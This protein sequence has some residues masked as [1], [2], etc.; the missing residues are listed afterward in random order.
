VF[1]LV[2][3]E[4]EHGHVRQR[5]IAYLG[6]ISEKR[7]QDVAARQAVWR[8]AERALAETESLSDAQ[9]ERMRVQLA[10]YVAMPARART[11][12]CL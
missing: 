9:R 4:R 2:K 11:E 8:S 6:T 5:G 7:V 3:S 1:K 12:R 10:R